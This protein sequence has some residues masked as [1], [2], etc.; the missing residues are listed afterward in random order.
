ME[1]WAWILTL[2]GGEVGGC[3]LNTGQLLEQSRGRMP[4]P[5]AAVTSQSLGKWLPWQ[6][7][8]PSCVSKALEMNFIYC[9]CSLDFLRA[10]WSVACFRP[11]WQLGRACWILGRGLCG[12]ALKEKEHIFVHGCGLPFGTHWMEQGICWVERFL[13]PRTS[14]PNTVHGS[15]HL[16]DGHRLETWAWKSPDLSFLHL[17]LC[18]PCFVV[19]RFNSGTF[20]EVGR[21]KIDQWEPGLSLFVTTFGSRSF[22]QALCLLCVV[23]FSEDRSVG[24]VSPQSSLKFQGQSFSWHVSSPFGLL[25]S[26]SV[27]AV[28]HGNSV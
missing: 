5:G 2:E 20:L 14:G 21:Y 4:C 15:L 22:Q 1:S 3:W 12:F 11:S 8:R 19:S 6:A 24:L 7:P 9:G 27:L 16:E 28:K 17:L 13:S 26:S 23:L 10:L 25:S 18:S